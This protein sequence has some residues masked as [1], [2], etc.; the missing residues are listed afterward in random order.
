MAAVAAALVEDR[1]RSE[2]T[3][4]TSPEAPPVVSAS[5]PIELAGGTAFGIAVKIPSSAVTT[6]RNRIAHIVGEL[7]RGPIASEPFKR[8]RL[9]VT[10][11]RA[12]NQSSNT[13]WARQLTLV[14]RAPRMAQAIPQE[15]DVTSITPAAVSRFLK[16][17]LL[18]QRPLVVIALPT[19]NSNN[20]QGS[21]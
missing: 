1:L 5:K 2:A 11:S 15:S 17:Y 21:R 19:T 13:W 18:G 16:T 4:T 7:A 14:L 20:S 12:A 8:A 9:A 6:T 3:F 10:A